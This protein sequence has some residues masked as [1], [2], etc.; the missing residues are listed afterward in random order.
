MLINILTEKIVMKRDRIQ[1]MNT[2][3][4]ICQDGAKKTIIVYRAN[5]SFRLADTY[6]RWLVEQGYL[7]FN[8]KQYKITPEG[9]RFLTTLSD[10]TGLISK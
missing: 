4:G 3:L 8:G 6:L 7:A 2:I 9:E 5:L 1:I 10:L